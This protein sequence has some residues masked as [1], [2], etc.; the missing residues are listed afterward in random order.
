MNKVSQP[1][2]YTVAVPTTAGTGSEVT[3]YAVITD[4]HRQYKLTVGSPLI[5]P[6]LAVVD[7]ELTY[8]LPPALT[9]A[10]GMDALTHAVES[11]TNNVYHPLADLLAEEAIY[12]IGRHLRTAVANGRH[13]EARRQLLYASLLAGL[14]F[15]YTRL[16]NVHAMA[17]PVGGWFDVPHGVANAILLPHVMEFNLPACLERTA[18][19]ASLLGEPVEGLSL[20]A[21][22]RRGVEAVRQLAADVGIPANLRAVGVEATRLEEMV[23]DALKSGN[24]AVN[25]RQT[26]A[27]D[28]EQLFRA[29]L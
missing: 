5:I 10:T 18:H 1:P 13:V 23:A 21:A 16:G 25:P 28:I 19:I 24:V 7:P 12:L 22:A 14:A 15:N 6:R 26:T 8:S 17:H 20:V 2:L 4:L 29:A 3:Q 9:A 27:A 11:Y